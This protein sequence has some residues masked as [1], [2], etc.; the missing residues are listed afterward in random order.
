MLS[1]SPTVPHKGVTV[2]AKSIEPI[3]FACTATLADA[4]MASKSPD[5]ERE[6]VL[7]ERTQ[8]VSG[9]HI[10]SSSIR[11]TPVTLKR[12]SMSARE[13]ST[14]LLRESEEM[15]DERK[16]ELHRRR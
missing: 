14:A 2:E 3:V 13:A 11:E 16:E 6:A 1:R 8:V 4:P 5:G 9:G 12:E 15:E 10:V 7:R